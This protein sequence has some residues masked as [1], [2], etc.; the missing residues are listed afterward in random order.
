MPRDTGE[1]VVDKQIAEL[2]YIVMCAIF[3]KFTFLENLKW[4]TILHVFIKNS[5][6]RN[7]YFL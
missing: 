4:H 5:Y 1:T 3:V 7:K 6:H 2:V